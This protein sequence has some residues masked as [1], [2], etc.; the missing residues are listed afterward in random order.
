[1]AILSYLGDGTIT[2]ITA[3]AAELAALSARP[4]RGRCVVSS[5]HRS[6]VKKIAPSKVGVQDGAKSLQAYY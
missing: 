2:A 5:S 4:P 1:M 3:I 6:S